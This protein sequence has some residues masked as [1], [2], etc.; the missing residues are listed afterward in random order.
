MGKIVDL[1]HPVSAG[2]VTWPGDPEVVRGRWSR[3]ED[4]GF[5]LGITTIGDHSGTHIGV[6]AHMHADGIT[7]DRLPV[8][9]L[10]RTAVVIDLRNA[11]RLSP[12]MILDWESTHGSVPEASVVL[13]RTGRSSY[14]GNPNLYRGGDVLNFPGVSLD[15]AMLLGDDRGVVG[16][17]IDALGIDPGEDTTFA[18]NRYWLQH[19][20]YHLE[21]LTHLEELPAVGTTLVVAPLPIAGAGGAPSRVIALIGGW[22]ER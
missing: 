22:D 20:R 13:V 9:L 1:T 12:A 2:I 17:G 21:N 5:E 14:F 15:A 6:G 3:I 18:T 19:H 10:I 16:L 11:T 7:I 4:D 8:N